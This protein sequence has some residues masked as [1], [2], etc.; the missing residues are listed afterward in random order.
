MAGIKTISDALIARL[1]DQ[2]EELE[3]KIKTFDG[4]A[5]DLLDEV[6]SVPFVGITLDSQELTELNTGGTVGEQ[7]LTF[8]LLLIA[9]DFSGPGFSIENC[10]GLIDDVIDALMGN[11]LGVAGLAP[12][13][14]GGL[15]KNASM[16]EEKITAYNL[17]I[18]TWQM[19][20]QV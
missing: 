18:K 1:E 16:E 9:E 12:L 3:G 17:K 15:E 6:Q 20:Q 7:H 13:E 11:N 10:Y 4:S 19:K 5:R 14:I 2:V 8:N